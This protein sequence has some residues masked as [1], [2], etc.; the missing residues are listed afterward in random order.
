VIAT[1]FGATFI[2]MNVSIVRSAESGCAVE[3]IAPGI[4]STRREGRRGTNRIALE[5]QI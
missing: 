5:K 2:E 3:I 1:S 4:G